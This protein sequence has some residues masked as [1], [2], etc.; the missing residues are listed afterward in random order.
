MINT[1]GTNAYVATLPMGFFLARFSADGNLSWVRMEDKIGTSLGIAAS[2]DG[3]IAVIGGGGLTVDGVQY[4]CL[5]WTILFDGNGNVNWVNPVIK[6]DE[7]SGSASRS[8]V[9]DE[10]ANCYVVGSYSLTVAFAKPAA[11]GAR[12]SK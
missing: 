5:S 10:Q 4:I 11:Y 12:L 2:P 9:M 1:H 6:V 7:H 8:V 3:H